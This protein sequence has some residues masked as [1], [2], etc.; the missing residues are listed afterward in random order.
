MFESENMKRFRGKD[1]VKVC[2]EFFLG[3]GKVRGCWFKQASDSHNP[4][5]P[6]IKVHKPPKSIRKLYHQL[7]T[8]PW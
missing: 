2:R 6:T 3:I 4:L 5:L 8:F 1:F 7:L